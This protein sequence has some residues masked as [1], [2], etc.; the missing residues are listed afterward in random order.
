MKITKKRVAITTAALTLVTAGIFGGTYAKYKTETSPTIEQARLAKFYLESDNTISLFHTEY[1][2]S[3][4]TGGKDVKSDG[5][6][7]WKLI[8]PNVTTTKNLS[9]TVNTEVKSELVFTGFEI[10]TNLPA[11]L[12]EKIF[13]K[14]GNGA[15]NTHT[16]AD[17]E[18]HTSIS[19][20]HVADVAAGTTGGQYQIPIEFKWNLENSTDDEETAAAI[21]QYEDSLSNG[22]LY[23]LQ[24][25]GNATLTQID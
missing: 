13:I 12:K 17:M 19:A 10:A 23:D 16:L 18:G 22:Q 3:L 9:F 11:E 24:I 15:S 2:N 7:N 25:S 8:A 6:D 4:G 5:S 14:V 20:I 21:K 1:D